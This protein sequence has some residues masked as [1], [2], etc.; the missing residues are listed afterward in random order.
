MKFLRQYGNKRSVF[1]TKSSNGALRSHLRDKIAEATGGEKVIETVGGVG[2]KIEG[3][4]N[5]RFFKLEKQKRTDHS[6]TNA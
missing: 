6:Y 3:Q 5:K 2:Y 1:T 4:I